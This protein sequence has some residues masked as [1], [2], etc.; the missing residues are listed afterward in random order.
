MLKNRIEIKDVNQWTYERFG[1]HSSLLNQD[2]HCG[3]FRS[4]SGKA[5]TKTLYMFHGG[6][7][8]DS[9]AAQAGLLPLVADILSQGSHENIQIVFPYI[10]TSFLHDHPTAQSKSFSNYFLKEVI[11][12]AEKEL[13]IQPENRLLSGWSM[14]GQ[15]ALNMFLRFPDQFGGVGVHFPTLVGFNYNDKREQEAY[16]QRQKV[17]DAMMHILVSEFQ[18]EFV[19]ISDFSNHDPLHLAKLKA[20]QLG[21]K[22]KIYFDVGQED[23][24]GLSEGARMLHEL[25]LDK[26]VAHQYELVP[27]GKHDGAFI[28][29]QLGKLLKHIL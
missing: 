26:K 7:A 20:G 2:L 23:E 24:F 15:A 3:F 1:L 6:N 17:S 9:Q 8:D 25:L 22:K 19:D 5:V 11:S 12:V 14:G 27:Q 16:A 18:K 29:T 21:N 10:G 28:Y 13:K 4:K